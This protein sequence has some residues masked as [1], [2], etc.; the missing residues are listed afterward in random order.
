MPFT[1]KY[2]TNITRTNPAKKNFKEFSTILRILCLFLNNF[3]R[4]NSVM[5]GKY[6]QLPVKMKEEVPNL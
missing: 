4:Y 2:H 3:L 5:D 1:G 6:G